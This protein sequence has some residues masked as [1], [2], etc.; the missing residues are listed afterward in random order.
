MGL[1]VGRRAFQL[2]D[3]L[4]LVGA[5]RKS[6]FGGAAGRGIRVQPRSAPTEEPLRRNR[7]FG[8]DGLLNS[9]YRRKR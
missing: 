9:T 5:K 8:F 3:F 6:R 1:S 4:Q 2:D 7:R